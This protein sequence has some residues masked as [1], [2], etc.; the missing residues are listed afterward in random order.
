MNFHRSRF[1]LCDDFYTEVHFGVARECF[2]KR[3]WTY[4][5]GYYICCGRIFL[6]VISV[7][8]GKSMCWLCGSNMF[9]ASLFYLKL[10]IEIR[11]MSKRQQLDQRADNRLDHWFSYLNCFTMVILGSFIAQC[12][13]WA[14]ATHWRLYFVLWL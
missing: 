8:C 2:I 6:V 4:I 3:R 12:L 11:N 10:R 1:S 9:L 7:K 13:V 14:K 5:Q